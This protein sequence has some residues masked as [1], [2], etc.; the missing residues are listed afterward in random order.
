MEC[1][2]RATVAMDKIVQAFA[3]G[4]HNLL[5][6]ELIPQDAASDSLNWVT[7]DGA[8][9]LLYGRQT[10]GG[11]GATG[12]NY[13]EHTAYRADGTAVRFR[14]ASTKIQYLNGDT[15]TDVITNLTASDVTFA[16]Y[17]SLAGAFVYIFSPDDGP[18]KICTANPG[19]HAA[20]YDSARN[21]KG[22]GLID[23]G[24]TILWGKPEDP[25]GLYGSYID[26]QD[27]A[28][29]TTVS[30]E[31]LG[32]GDGAET[33]FS[34]T[35]AFKAGGSKRTCFG[36]EI[37]DGVETF[38]DDFN[39]VL[40]GSAGG[41]G[42]INYMTGAWAVSFNSAPASAANNITGDYQWEDSNVKGVTD[43]T[44]SATRAAGE[45][46]VLRQD[47]GGD[48]IKVVIPHDGSYFSMKTRSA[49]QLTLDAEDVAPV[50]E[51]IRSDI[52]ISTLRSAVPTSV[53]IV[54]MNTANTSEPRMQILERNPVGDNFITRSLFDHFDFSK[55]GY[56]DA[57]IDTWDRYILVGCATTTGGNDR[58][59]LCDMKTNTVDITDYGVRTF[60][61]N[62]GYVYGGDVVSDTTFELFTGFDDLGLA[63][64]NYWESS[65]ALLD[66]TRL[67]KIK[68]LRIS[69]KISPDQSI[70]VYVSYDDAPYIHLGTIVGSGD[71]V[72][73]S[74]AYS[75]GTT[76]IGDAPIGGE[77]TTSV[78][79]FIAELKLA[80]TKFRKRK[81]KFVATGIGFVSIDGLTD[82]HIMLF[83]D[84]LPKTYRTKQNVSL[85]GLTTDVDDSVI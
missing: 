74:S 43:F 85:D 9:E 15:W 67:K 51:L 78:Y 49:Y 2:S 24:R 66:T 23:K 27:S 48:A 42:T 52:G 84:K 77:A 10:Q 75:V 26:G 3:T 8:I 54:Y 69:G 29:Y 20:L 6:D 71:Y 31:V 40:T 70:R 46:F 63:V 12:K 80:G 13:G 61:K 36:I 16:N 72:D 1:T 18:H 53:G 25:T 50:N 28:V 83:Q 62:G 41:T 76:M 59:L 30:A 21:F 19:S 73:V 58:L 79:R 4:T 34:G 39:G 65:G 60:T 45:G 64:T 44:K 57:A 68:R 82:R 7:R 81:I 5:K 55:Y 35:L 22:Y 14:K 37:T 32:S 33:D 38:T 17:Q 47:A 11:D 56:H